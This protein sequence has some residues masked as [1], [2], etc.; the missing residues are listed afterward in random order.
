MKKCWKKNERKRE[1][2]RGK[3]IMMGR[4]NLICEKSSVKFE[5][6]LVLGSKKT[7]VKNTQ[8]FVDKKV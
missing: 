1:R 5:C 2:K 4:M 7:I 6:I 3:T 8:S